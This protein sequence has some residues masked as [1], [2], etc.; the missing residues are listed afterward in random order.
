MD[1]KVTRDK[2]LSRNWPW[3]AGM[4]V[5]LLFLVTQCIQF[6]H[7]SIHRHICMYVSTFCI[8]PLFS[9]T[10]GDKVEVYALGWPIGTSCSAF[11]GTYIKLGE[12]INMGLSWGEIVMKS[13]GVR[14]NGKGFKASYRFEGQ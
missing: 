6:P 5:M 3:I 14:G 7:K 12:S 13:D 10:C 9:P 1:L 2:L 8:L 11:E 4:Y